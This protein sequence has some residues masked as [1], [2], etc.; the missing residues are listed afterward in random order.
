MP[1]EIRSAVKPVSPNTVSSLNV[2]Q[3]F[4]FNCVTIFVSNIMYKHPLRDFHPFSIVF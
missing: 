2:I 3:N 4:E 1:Y